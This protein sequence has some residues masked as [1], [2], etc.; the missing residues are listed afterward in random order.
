MVSHSKS[1]FSLI[2]LAIGLAVVTILILSVSASAGIRDN[3]RVQSAA[4][5]V[6][7]LRLAAENYL[8]TGKVNYAGLTFESLKTAKLLPGNF[9]PSQANPW[10]GDYVL[11]ANG[12]STRFDIGIS[13][14]NKTDADKL[15]SYFASSASVINFN[16]GAGT[17][18]ATF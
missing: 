13:G 3:A 2:E 5:S 1:G 17:W 15:S 14:L 11:A 7:T 9:N 8:V 10:G 18:T 6:E 16:E 12:D 4:K